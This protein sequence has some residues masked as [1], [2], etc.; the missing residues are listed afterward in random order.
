MKLD[1]LLLQPAAQSSRILGSVPNRQNFDL[2]KFSVDNEENSEWPRA[3]KFRFPRK[4]R[5]SRKSLRMFGKRLEKR[6]DRVVEFKAYARF[7]AF[8]IFNRLIPVLN[9]VRIGDDLESHRLARSRF[10]I[11]AETTS[12]EAPRPG[13]FS[14][15]SARRS[16]SAAS[17]GVSSGSVSADV[18]NS[19]KSCASLTRS[20]SGRAFAASRISVALI[21]SKLTQTYRSGKFVP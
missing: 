18:I 5:R 15:S 1:E 7:L 3:E 4:P 11:S 12:A 21:K 14:A 19:K 16:N 6:A 9:G 8:V 20:F 17:S 2:S 13:F 10:W